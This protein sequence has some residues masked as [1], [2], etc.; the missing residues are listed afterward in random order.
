MTWSSRYVSYNILYNHV[1]YK[2][3]HT[4]MRKRALTCNT[5]PA[6]YDIDSIYIYMP[7]YAYNM[8]V[9][10]VDHA[11]PHSILTYPECTL[12]KLIICSSLVNRLLYWA[13]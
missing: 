7:I 4:F 10:A 12:M 13:I 2:V 9:T 8:I 1:Y 6:Y 11:L 5:S 3:V